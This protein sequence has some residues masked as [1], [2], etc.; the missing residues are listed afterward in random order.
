MAKYKPHTGIYMILNVKNGRY[1]IGSAMRFN[2]RWKEHVRGLENNRHHS[3]FLQRDW[4]KCWKENFKFIVVEY[5]NSEELI[6]TEQKY[7]DSM[8]PVYNSSPIAGSQLGYKHTEEAKIKMSESRPKNFSPMTGKHHTE[9]TRLRISATKTGVKLGKYSK[10]RVEKTAKAMRIG[11]KCLLEQEVKE[12][13]RLKKLGFTAIKIA[14]L[15]GRK[16]WPV[17]DVLQG[18]TYRWVSN[19]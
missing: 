4:N 19:G 15:I 8:M 18:R 2:K 16:V 6:K 3:R 17:Y 7:L 11:K 12:I 10:D 9:E 1:Y 5:C 13:W 14:S